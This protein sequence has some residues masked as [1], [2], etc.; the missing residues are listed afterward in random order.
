MRC[1]KP[2]AR[3]CHWP[4]KFARNPV[5]ISEEDIRSPLRAVTELILKRQSG[6]LREI[7]VAA[8]GAVHFESQLQVR[9]RIVFLVHSNQQPALISF[10]H[11]R[12]THP[13]ELPETR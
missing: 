8:F 1:D 12:I 9:R 10:V 2:F 3:S 13:V 4:V 5:G 11:N 6:C 7:Y